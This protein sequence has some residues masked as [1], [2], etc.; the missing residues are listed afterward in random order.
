MT[1]ILVSRFRLDLQAVNQKPLKLGRDDP[2]HS[3][4]MDASEHSGRDVGSLV[5]RRFDVVGS[6]G[7]SLAPSEHGEV[8]GGAGFGEDELEEI[9]GD[10]AVGE[11]NV[12]QQ[13]VL[14]GSP[15]SASCVES[16][17]EAARSVT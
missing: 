4:H 9:D 17:S 11:C 13:S 8:T 5:F 3:S 14:M 15:E 7:A 16:A 12:L 10:N 2:L 6:L 1:A